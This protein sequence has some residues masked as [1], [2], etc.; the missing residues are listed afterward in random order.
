MDELMIVVKAKKAAKIE[1]NREELTGMIDAVTAQYDGLVYTEDQLPEAKKDRAN[2]NK[3]LGVIEDERKRVKAEVMKPYEDFEAELKVLTGRIKDVISQIDDQVKSFEAEKKAEKKEKL[4]AYYEDNIGALKELVPFE[5]A[6]FDP[7]ML[8]ATVS[9][10]KAYQQISE[11]IE[12]V[13][14]DLR[15]LDGMETEFKDTIKAYYYKC[16]DLGETLQENARLQAVKRMEAQ[17]QKEEIQRR[18]A[19]VEGLA[20]KFDIPA[21]EMEKPADP[22]PEE[23]LE[24]SFTV[25]GTLAQLKSLKAYM[26]TLGVEFK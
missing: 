24:M 5:K 10:E 23:K 20:E 13:G 8:N 18:Q 16:F 11:R 1:W 2:L 3:A 7:K 17:R 9:L 25:V 4:I 14:N 22:E 19:A 15:S 21:P 26:E 6:I 12:R